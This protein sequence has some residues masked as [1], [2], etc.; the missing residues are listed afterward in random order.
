MKNA[1]F[2]A[3]IFIF[4]LMRSLWLLNKYCSILSSSNNEI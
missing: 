1:N 3:N 4:T 2:L